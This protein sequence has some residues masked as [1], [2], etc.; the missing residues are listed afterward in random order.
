M[1]VVLLVAIPAFGQTPASAAPS[2]P[3]LRVFDPSLIDKTI[4]PCENF[5]QYSCNGWFKRNPLPPDQIAYGR[6]TELYELNRLHL[7]EIL[8]EAA[9]PAATRSPNEQK[10]GD[11]YASCMDTSAINKAG[12]APLRPELDRIAALKSTAELPALLGH[13]HLSEWMRSS[14]SARIR[15]MATRTRLFRSTAPGALGCPNAIIT[16]GRIA[17]SDEQR[18]QY[19]DHVHKMLVLAGEPEAQASKD[20]DA[21]MAI[22]TAWPRRLS[23]LRNSAIRRT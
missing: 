3:A 7:K 11:E 4:D 10:I 18:K 8:E 9:K 12:I 1:F 21:V 20:A 19:V 14:I 5:Y 15:I 16:R 2:S 22:E 17:K 13:L 23:P 6:F